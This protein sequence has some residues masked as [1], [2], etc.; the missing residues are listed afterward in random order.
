MRAAWYDENG[1]AGDVLQVGEQETPEA[2]P[3]EVRIAL[4]ASGV[5]PSDVKLRAG[6]RH[7][8][9]YPRVIANSDGAG[10]VD[11]VG[12]GVAENWLAKRVWLYNG[13][14]QGR[15]FGTAAEYIALDVDL[16]TELPAAIGLDAGAT[17]GIPCLTAHRAVFWDGPVEGLTVLVTGGAGAVGHYAVQLAK[18][19]GA[20]VLSTISSPEKAAHAAAGG[21]DLCIN[22]REENVVER[23]MEATGGAGVDRIV[24]VDFGGNLAQTYEIIKNA[25]S[26]TVYASDGAAAPPLPVFPLM[27]KNVSLRFLV[28]NSVPHP[29]RKQAQSEITA[30]LETGNAICPIAGRFP[31]SEI[32]AAHTLVESGSKLGT[33]IVEPRQG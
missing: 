19:G 8:M 29:A 24:E 18:W 27:A 6:L 32:A 30:W 21:A 10:I 13:Q 2:G 12:Q 31:L 22:Y 3:G 33:V 9:A 20:R 28:L 17:L 1:A 14:R 11:Q 5:N 4:E 15:A 25:G 7:P 16:V 26:V 23:V